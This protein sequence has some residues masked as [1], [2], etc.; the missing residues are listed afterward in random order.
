MIDFFETAMCRSGLLCGNCRKVHNGASFRREMLSIFGSPA[1]ED[2][3]CPQ[4]KEWIED[5]KPED[6]STNILDPII[7]FEKICDIIPKLAGPNELIRRLIKYRKRALSD[8]EGNA[9][10]DSCSTGIRHRLI[11][12]WDIEKKRLPAENAWLLKDGGELWHYGSD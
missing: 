12:S 11:K 10:C 4:G 1:D 7:R 2:F 6:L 5:K 9:G 8:L 3:V